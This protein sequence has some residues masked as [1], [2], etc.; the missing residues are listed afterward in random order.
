MEENRV[1]QEKEVWKNRRTA[2]GAGAWQSVAFLLGSPPFALRRLDALGRML[3][4]ITTTVLVLSLLAIFGTPHQTAANG[5][6]TNEST[7]IG[8]MTQEY[9]GDNIAE[10]LMIDYDG[11]QPA[12][13]RYGGK[14]PEI[15]S[16][17]N[18][19]KFGVQRRY[20]EYRKVKP[21][22]GW[23]EI[24]SYPFSSPD[25]LQIVTTYAVYPAY[26][27]DGELSSYNFD[28]KNNR[29]MHVS[30]VL[31]ELGL[32]E[33]SVVQRVKKLYKPT[34]SSLSLGKVA[35]S[36]FLIRQGPIG[37]VTQLLLEAVVH[38][39]GTED[40]KYF[41]SYSP[42]LN[43]LLLM[44]RRCL[45]D[46]AD[47][48]R[49]DPPLSYQRPVAGSQNGETGKMNLIFDTRGLEVL[50]SGREYLL[51]GVVYFSL[52]KLTAVANDRQSVLERIRSRQGKALRLDSLTRSV[53][54][55]R[56][57][58]YPTWLAVYETGRNEDTRI[59]FDLYIQTDMADYLFHTSV[60]G[61]AAAEYR[62]EIE[63]RLGSVS[64]QR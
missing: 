11:N 8:V 18:A 44:N 61:D 22:S 39:Q 64:F 41:F 53:E 20:D 24:K 28:K 55:S 2:W 12:L 21:E 59:C 29:F 63:R 36:G 14:N 1:R 43:E 15:E 50:T 10:I 49:M 35:I 46:P 30:D 19:I 34:D 32:D 62:A 33:R 26:G 57:L 5:S 6:I 58:A 52:E 40:W 27:T 25:H 47:M 3:R 7:K 54:H 9:V 4:G 38:K 13:V 37:P 16:F 42:V 23:L 56:R 45:F 31:A 60:A 48:D 51:D 17:N